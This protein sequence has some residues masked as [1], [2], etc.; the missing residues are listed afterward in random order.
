MQE[1]ILSR[2]CFYFINDQVYHR[3]EVDTYSEAMNTSGRP[4]VEFNWGASLYS[5]LLKGSVSF[6]DIATL[7]IYYG[8]RR[9]SFETDVL[10]AALGMLQQYSNLSG[11][12]LLEGLPAPLDVSLLFR[13]YLGAT[14]DFP[15][16]PRRKEYPSYSWTG[17]RQVIHWEISVE[18]A[19]TYPMSDATKR[20]DTDVLTWINWYAIESGNLSSFGHTGDRTPASRL[21]IN[22]TSEIVPLEF[23]SFASVASD[24][25]ARSIASPKPFPILLFWTIC[26]NL[27]LTR[28]SAVVPN[29]YQQPWVGADGEPEHVYQV[30]D[31]HGQQCGDMTLDTC[32]FEG[33]RVAKFVLVAKQGD[34]YWALLLSWNEEGLAER[35]GVGQ[36]KLE[37]LRNALEPGPRWKEIVLG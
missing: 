34:N 20:E 13:R 24:V 8:S 3:C 7:L 32:Y 12:L 33:S 1:E 21:T 19:I 9:L 17:W 31:R 16:E 26:V 22:E 11:N 18:E 5:S 6:G 36:L 37:C 29:R 23:S 4:L 25:D 35:W 27:T 28:T 2:R 10:R 15:K 14:Q 30:I